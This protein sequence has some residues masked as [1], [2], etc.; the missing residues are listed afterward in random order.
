MG[1]GA[2]GGGVEIESEQGGQSK[3]LIGRV[4][5]RKSRMI[6][7]RETEEENGGGTKEANLYEPLLPW[8]CLSC[9]LS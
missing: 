6:N 8:G 9:R 3:D 7:K 5:L 2:G 4:S 1:E